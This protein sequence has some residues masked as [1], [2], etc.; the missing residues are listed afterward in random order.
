MTARRRAALSHRGGAADRRRD[1]DGLAAVRPTRTHLQVIR[2]ELPLPDSTVIDV[3]CGAG[4]LT[5]L[6]AQE[7][8]H[9]IGVDPSEDAIARAVADAGLHERYIVGRAEAL[10]VPDR[11]ADAVTFLNS[12]HHIASDALTRGLAEA[13]RVLRAEGVVYVQ[14]PLAE[15]RYYEVV[16][17]LEDE[18]EVRAAAQRA[19]REG[20]RSGL[21]LVKELE[22]DAVVHHRDFGS[23]RNRVVLVD[24]RR[25]ATFAAIASEVEER[26]YAA[27]QR[28][29]D[30][31]SFLQPTRVT[32]LR[33]ALSTQV[34]SER[35]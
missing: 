2:S 19:L 26:F 11:R 30:G 33:S 6:L 15:G 21:A 25:A 16:R 3:G 17:L 27:G 35:E 4:S 13:C 10:P 29:G 23:F 20:G 22:Y 14:E 32:L 1:D 8:A 5:R 9:V 7:G 12:L 34:E 24:G 28:D 18:A 31:W